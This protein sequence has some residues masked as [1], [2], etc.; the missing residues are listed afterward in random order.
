MVQSMSTKAQA[1]LEE[2]QALPPA[3]LR[4]LCQQVNRIAA[5][6]EKLISLPVPVSDK[7][8]EAA[9]DEVTGCTAGSNS[10]QRLLDDRRHDRERDEAWLEARKR[11]RNGG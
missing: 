7:E 10:L 5:E 9:L 8:F 6:A 4:E 2:I 3:E 11:E 1:M